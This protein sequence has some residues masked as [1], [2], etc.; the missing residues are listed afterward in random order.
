M[1]NAMV[2]ALANA[3]S[4]TMAHIMVASVNAMIKAR[5]VSTQWSTQ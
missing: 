1:V 4:N 3:K 2:I 5:V